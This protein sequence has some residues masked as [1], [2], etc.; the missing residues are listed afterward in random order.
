MTERQLAPATRA[1]V[2]DALS[3]GLRY[4]RAGKRTHD[5]DNLMADAAADHLVDALERS[6]FVIMR[7]AAL[8][9]H[10]GPDPAHP[11]MRD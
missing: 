6:G 3:H 10:R 8:P 2:R 7:K 11:T 5:R 9:A 4:N 1:E